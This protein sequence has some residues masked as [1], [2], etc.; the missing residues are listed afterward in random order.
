[1]EGH[2]TKVLLLRRVIL[3]RILSYARAHMCLCMYVHACVRA[4][5]CARAR[6]CVCVFACVC[7]YVCE[8]ARRLTACV[9]TGARKQFGT[10]CDGQ[11][12]VFTSVLTPRWGTADAE[13][14]SPRGGNPEL[15]KVRSF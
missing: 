12:K 3:V 6:V 5:V 1:M 4:C 15:L 2:L 9:V 7:A 10:T 8:F 11:A 13:M 14:K